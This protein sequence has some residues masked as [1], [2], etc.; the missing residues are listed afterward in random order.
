[1]KKQLLRSFLILAVLSGASSA[2][3]TMT[4]D[5][6]NNATTIGGGTFKVSTGVTLNAAATAT[7][8][9][10]VSSHTNGDKE[11]CALS[12]DPKIGSQTKPAT[13]TTATVGMANYTGN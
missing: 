10:A 11:Y 6:T 12:A 8:Y 13:Q 1:M 2:F 3:A 5:T 7:A 9:A 4:L